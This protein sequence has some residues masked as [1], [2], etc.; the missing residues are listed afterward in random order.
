MAADE[1]KKDPSVLNRWIQHLASI[2]IP[3]TCAA[4]IVLNYLIVEGHY[5]AATTFLNESKGTLKPDVP[6]EV[7]TLRQTVWKGIVNNQIDDAIEAIGRIDANFLARHPAIRFNLRKHQ[8]F[9]IIEQGD[10]AS[11]LAFVQQHIGPCVQD[12]PA[13][14]P[15][16]EHVM[17]VVAF[18]ERITS[19][20]TASAKEREK[21]AARVI[22]AVFETYGASREPYLHVIMR[23]LSYTQQQLM[24]LGDASPM[25][26]DPGI[27]W[28]VATARGGSKTRCF[29]RSSHAF[30]PEE[31]MEDVPQPGQTAVLFG[32]D[33]DEYEC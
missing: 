9:E 32:G 26:L 21:T 11:T 8:L 30:L 29:P 27:G 2:P 19:E 14:L 15:D 24:E 23:Y 7:L 3:D 33:D 18:P 25:L 17:A 31:F 10:D 4:Q 13:L 22:D 16:L 5:A 20:V 6:L 28:F 1:H 12:D